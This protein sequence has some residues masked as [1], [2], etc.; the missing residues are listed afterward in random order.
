LLSKEEQWKKYSNAYTSSLDKIADGTVDKALIEVSIKFI[1]SS[2]VACL[3]LLK[4][5]AAVE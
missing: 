5:F 4:I 2:T 3:F 1:N